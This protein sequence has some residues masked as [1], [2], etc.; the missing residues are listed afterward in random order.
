MCSNLTVN[1][2]IGRACA[3]APYAVAGIT[4]GLTTTIGL[5][6]MPLFIAPIVVAQAIDFGFERLHSAGCIEEKMK[7]NW[8][9]TLVFFA[10]MAGALAVGIIF[11]LFTPVSLGIFAGISIC[12]AFGYGVMLIPTPPKNESE[13]LVR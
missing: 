11:G 7:A 6:A 2:F 8:L 12:I 1:Q 10:C 5:I 3:I 13:A 4:I 9:G